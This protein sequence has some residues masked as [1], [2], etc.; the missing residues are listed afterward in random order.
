ME[1]SSCVSQHL[2]G[3]DQTLEGSTKRRKSLFHA[4][5]RG[6]AHGLLTLVSGLFRGRASLQDA[7]MEQNYSHHD[8]WE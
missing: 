5:S 4:N 7:M 1:K 8:S 6:S 2:V 3:C